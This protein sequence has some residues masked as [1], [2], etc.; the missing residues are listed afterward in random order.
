MVSIYVLKLRN[1]KYYIGKTNNPDFRIDLHFQANGSVWTKLHQPIEV[2]EVIKNCDDYDEDKYTLKYMAEYGIENVRGGS[3]VQ[4][5]LSVGEIKVI[6]QMINGSKDYCFKCGQAGHFANKCQNVL[7]CKYCGGNFKTDGSLKS[8]EK[9]CYKNTNLSM[10]SWMINTVKEMV[11][12][13]KV[14]EVKNAKDVMEVCYRC[15]RTGHFSSNC[16]AKW[17]INGYKLTSAFR[18]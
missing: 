3:F 16:Y 12:G 11:V 14:D 10:M 1:N 15:G 2:I 17:H 7:I 13:S 8:H 9:C 5:N 6:N 4:I 18:K